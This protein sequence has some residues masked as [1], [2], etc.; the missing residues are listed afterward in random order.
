LP[1]ASVE[2]YDFAIHKSKTRAEV[3]YLGLYF[4]LDSRFFDLDC[5][6]E[7]VIEDSDEDDIEDGEDV[8]EDLE[9]IPGTYR[10]SGMGYCDFS[11]GSGYETSASK[12]LTISIACLK[13]CFQHFSMIV[14]RHDTSLDWDID[15]RL[16]NRDLL[17]CAPTCLEDQSLNGGLPVAISNIADPSAKISDASLGL[18]TVGSLLRV[19]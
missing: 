8:P 4:R 14:A 18:L 10:K 11:N 2:F 12:H 5:L 16:G 15:F 3:I 1:R 7:D 9:G 13:L 19:S 17:Y 6:P